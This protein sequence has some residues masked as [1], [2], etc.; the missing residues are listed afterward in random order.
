MTIKLLKQW[1]RTYIKKNTNLERD[2]RG[3]EHTGSLMILSEKMQNC[4][5]SK[6]SLK[7][8]VN[9]IKAPMHFFQKKTYTQNPEIFMHIFG[10]EGS[11]NPPKF[12]LGPDGTSFGDVHI[13]WCE[14]ILQ[15]SEKHRLKN[16]SNSMS[17]F[18][19]KYI[20]ICIHWKIWRLMTK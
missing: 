11:I 2:Q 1:C 4:N 16:S 18:L 20:F 3:K 19:L 5:V 9:P 12:M 10:G 8:K 6:L 17:S 14:K 15:S 13:Y 7:V